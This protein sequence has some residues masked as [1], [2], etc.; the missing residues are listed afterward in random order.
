MEKAKK[1]KKVIDRSKGN[2]SCGSSALDDCTITDFTS[3]LNQSGDEDDMPPYRQKHFLMPSKT[4]RML[5]VGPSGSGKSNLLMNFLLK[6]L[7]YDK[8]YIYTKHMDQDC[9]KKLRRVL[10]NVEYETGEQILTIDNDPENIISP[11]DL[12]PHMQN[13]VVFDDLVLADISIQRKITEMFVR[14]R[15]ANCSCFYLSQMYH[16]IPR[17]IRLNSTHLCI[18]DV[19]NKREM[20]LLASEL[21]NSMPRDDFIDM[22][23]MCTEKPFDFMYIDRE[24]KHFPFRRNL[25]NF[26][27]NK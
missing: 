9:Y 25:N 24:N 5:L 18:F 15:H 26:Y 23:N 17:D 10:E 20:S 13:L 19:C 8:I 6:F 7:D 22:Y 1:T 11:G 14:G 12:D 4:F 27:V 3:I 16:K 21:N 2:Y